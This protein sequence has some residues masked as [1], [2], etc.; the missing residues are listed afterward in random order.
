M[1]FVA[2]SKITIKEDQ[3]DALEESFKRRVHLV[4]DFEGFISLNFLRNNKDP[5]KFIG[6]FKFQDEECFKNYMKSEEHRTSHDR[7]DSAITDAIQSNSLEFFTQLT[8]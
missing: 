6:I 1:V 5:T 4:D 2:I 3:A 8:D 7:T